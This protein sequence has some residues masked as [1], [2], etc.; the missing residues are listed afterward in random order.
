MICIKFIVVSKINF[1]EKRNFMEN[2]QSV[3]EKQFLVCFNF[4]TLA[5][6]V[7]GFAVIL[8]SYHVRII[9]NHTRSQKI[10]LVL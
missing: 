4:I 2:K 9:P 1:M 10:N 6:N 5:I 3:C 7:E 8:N